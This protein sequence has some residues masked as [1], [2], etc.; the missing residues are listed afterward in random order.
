[1]K[2]HL[3]CRSVVVSLGLIA[4]SAVTLTSA[5]ADPRQ[6]GCPNG[7]TLMAVADLAPQGYQV[8]G[9]V[10]DPNSGIK[11]YGRPG[12]GDGQVCAK[13]TGPQTTSWGGQLYEFW[14]NNKHA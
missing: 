7:Y 11:S 3:V 9:M 2:A 13:A 12:N 14:D 8:P 4:A 6:G 1:M 5:Q 10:D